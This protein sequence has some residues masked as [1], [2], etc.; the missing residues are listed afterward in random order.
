MKSDGAESVR[1]ALRGLGSTVSRNDAIQLA[2]DGQP[3]WLVGLVACMA[4][5]L[6]RRGGPGSTPDAALALLKDN[7]PAILLAHE[8]M[9]FDRV[10]KRVAV[11]LCGHTHGG[12]VNL[13]IAGLIAASVRYGAQPCLRP[14]GGER[15]ASDHFGGS[16]HV[17]HAR[18]LHASAGSGGSDDQR[19]GRAQRLIDP[20]F[21]TTL[22][23]SFTR[24]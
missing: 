4:H 11:T 13:P 24:L 22:V 20:Y 6:P 16:G 21:T 8:P 12:Q 5:P 2:K 18:P 7:A 23:P 14:H 17:L 1:R 10:P 3:F 15:P 9:I 19:R